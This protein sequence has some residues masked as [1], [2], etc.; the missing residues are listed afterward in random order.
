MN[1]PQP[2]SQLLARFRGGGGVRVVTKIDS[3]IDPNGRPSPAPEPAASGSLPDQRPLKGGDLGA[4]KWIDGQIDSIAVERGGEIRGEQSGLV[5]DP[6]LTEIS[7]I[8]IDPDQATAGEFAQT[9]ETPVGEAPLGRRQQ[10]TR[11]LFQIG[12]TTTA[13]RCR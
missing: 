6:C 10:A 3:K 4:A 5:G 1:M 7:A 2:G 9:G 8:G 13:G 12:I 11:P